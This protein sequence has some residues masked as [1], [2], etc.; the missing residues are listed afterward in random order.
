[1]LRLGPSWSAYARLCGDN[2]VS[3]QSRAYEAKHRP[4]RQCKRAKLNQKPITDIA[5]GFLIPMAASVKSIQ[6]LKRIAAQRVVTLN[7]QRV[8][9]DN[10]YAFPTV[11]TDDYYTILTVCTVPPAMSVSSSVV[12]PG[13]VVI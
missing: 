2:T 9:S 5:I 7:T 8:F 1:M 13:Q 4:L 11:G 6:D 10:P 3:Q 12:H